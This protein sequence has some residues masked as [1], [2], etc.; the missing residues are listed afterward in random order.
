M[1]A[2]VVS[3]LALYRGVSFIHE[4][5]H[6]RSGAIPGFFWGW[7]LVI[8]VPLLVPSFMYA[9]VH[10]LHHPDQRLAG[11]LARELV[12][13]LLVGLLDPVQ[14]PG[15]PHHGAQLAAAT[16]LGE[17]DVR[18]PDAG[19]GEHPFGLRGPIRVRAD[20]HPGRRVPK[21]AQLSRVRSRCR[22]E[23]SASGKRACT[24]SQRP[25]HATGAPNP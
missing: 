4:L 1:T 19:L 22:A 24:S 8:G 23:R 6:L 7:N 10:Q 18:V 3:V 12:E 2:W 5:T 21:P 9:G 25:S 11:R 14:V 17:E 16:V 15:L 20:P 13:E